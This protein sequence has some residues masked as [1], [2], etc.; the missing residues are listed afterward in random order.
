VIFAPEAR[1]DLV[2]LTDWIAERAGPDIALAYAARL[3]AYCLGFE[4]AGERGRRR[5]DLR[6]GLR[7]T[8]FER[9]VTVVF[10]ATET[11]VTI[12]RLFYGGQNWPERSS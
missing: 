2:A 4:F 7:V 10:S 1:H 11:E 12:L 3:E 8:G 6:P 9:R 5:D